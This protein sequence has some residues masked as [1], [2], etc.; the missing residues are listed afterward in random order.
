[1]K[2]VDHCSHSGGFLFRWRSYLPLALL[3]FFAL[4]LRD[5]RYPFGSHGWDQ[6][7][8]L[9]CLAL[10]LIGLLLRVYTIGTAPVGTSER[11]TVNPRASALN[12]AG[13]YSVVRHPLYIGNT[14]VA[15]GL[16][17]VPGTWYLPVI[18]LLAS[19]L[20]HER[21]AAREEA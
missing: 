7:W 20:Y 3:P 15:L 17:L 16:S 14:I 6:I 11:S 9:G 4:S 19:L 13:I 10:S 2:L 18:V 12:T 21:I 5:A 1:M 8:E